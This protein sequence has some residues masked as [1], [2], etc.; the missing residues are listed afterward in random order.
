MCNQLLLSALYSSGRPSQLLPLC[1]LLLLACQPSF[2]QIRLPLILRSK[3]AFANNDL[4]RPVHTANHR[5]GDHQPFLH[6]RFPVSMSVAP[7]P[8]KKKDL[9]LKQTTNSWPLPKDWEECGFVKKFSA[10]ASFDSPE[11]D[12]NNSTNGLIMCDNLIELYAKIEI[13][14]PPRTFFAQVLSPVHA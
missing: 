12:G 3:E 6:A 14:T 10:L 8:P 4:T 2:S 5:S 7:P 13:G 1:V 9:N 11:R